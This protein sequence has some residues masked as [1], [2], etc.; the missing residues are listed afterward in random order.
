MHVSE[1]CGVLFRDNKIIV[2]NCLGCNQ[3]E[4]NKNKTSRS[5]LETQKHNIGV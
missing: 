3:S 4:D 5:H 2:S 1:V